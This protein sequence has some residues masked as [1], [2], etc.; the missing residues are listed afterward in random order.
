MKNTVFRAHQLLKQA[1]DGSRLS[2]F[3]KKVYKPI[4]A[5]GRFLGDLYGDY[6]D[7][8]KY[9]DSSSNKPTALQWL[10][11]R[12]PV[13]V[14]QPG[15]RLYYDPATDPKYYRTLDDLAW[16]RSKSLQSRLHEAADDLAS[17]HGAYSW[18]LDDGSISERHRALD[19]AARATANADRT[20]LQ[21]DHSFGAHAE[22]ELSDE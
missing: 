10:E 8:R 9:K 4:A 7:Y 2:D 18:A 21:G 15:A 5:T 13:K 11:N 20:W 12:K 14:T 1:G 16:N 19:L 3:A 22:R 17:A 6:K